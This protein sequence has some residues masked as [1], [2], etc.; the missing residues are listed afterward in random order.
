MLQLLRLTRPLNLL[1]IALT[2]AAIRY[3]VVG[4]YLALNTAAF[5]DLLVDPATTVFA[6]VPGNVFTHAFSELHFWLLVLSTVLIAAGGNVINDYFDTRID[7]INKP[8]EVIVGRTVKRRI[9]M[10]T[11]AVLSA[12]GLL[13]G[14]L[15]AWRSGQLQWAPIPLFAVA[16]LWAYST[17]LKRVLLLGN[18]VVALLSALVPLTVGLYEI[19]ALGIAYPKGM[20]VPAQDGRLYEAAFDYNTPWF[21]ILL[22][23]FF[24]FLTTLARELQK[25]L[26]DVP[27]DRAEGRRTIP[28]VWGTRWAKALVLAYLA[29][30]LLAVVYLR[31]AYLH[32][33]L[34]Y[35]Y[36]G[37]GII[38]PLLVSA[39]FTFNA[40]TR[41]A[42]T[43]AD[44]LLKA[45]MALA[46][47]YA[48]LL[49]HTVWSIPS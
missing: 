23:A 10:F 3:G 27:G 9:A 30:T 13:L 38:A 22:F 1:I 31:M 15:V 47:G 6:R 41:R 29:A 17:G 36:V 49:G 25:D 20:Q 18:G 40:R 14:V 42:Y 33:P 2:M 45:A 12:I 5:Q 16:A 4:A 34:S 35:W 43:T 48:F 7:R 37:L 8:E 19:T 21:C 24:A 46:I 28:I 11:H 26:A 39:G 32:D 44:H